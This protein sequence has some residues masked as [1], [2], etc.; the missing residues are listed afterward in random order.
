MRSKELINAGITDFSS[1]VFSDEGSILPENINSF[2][3]AV[4]KIQKFNIVYLKII[5][6]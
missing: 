4:D 3:N 6:T 5:V 2:L 1:I